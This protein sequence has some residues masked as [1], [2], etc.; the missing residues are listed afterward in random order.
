LTKLI[1]DVILYVGKVEQ[2]DDLT[3]V[4]GKADGVPMGS[5]TIY[6]RYGDLLVWLSF[7]VTAAVLA[8]A[9]FSKHPRQVP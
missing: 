4:V 6:T 8:L 5:G 3:A 2:N 7:T 1:N 9:I